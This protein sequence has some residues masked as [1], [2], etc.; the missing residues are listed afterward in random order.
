MKNYYSTIF[1]FFIIHN[2]VNAQ[3]TFQKTFSGVAY[4][5]G[6]CVQQTSDGG[7]II[8]GNTYGSFIG[9]GYAVKTNSNGDTTWTKIFQYGGGNLVGETASGFSFIVNPFMVYTNSNGDTI[10]TKPMF[11]PLNALFGFESFSFYP[12]DTNFLAIGTT[13]SL[14]NNKDFFFVSNGT[15][16]P[17]YGTTNLEYGSSVQWAYGGGVIMVGT[18]RDFFWNSSDIYLIRVYSPF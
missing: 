1:F 17:S 5:R 9:G 11:G 7:Y 3:T 4:A 12:G 16:Y 18:T 13:Q 10:S 8:V 2:F 15:T 14:S 6:K